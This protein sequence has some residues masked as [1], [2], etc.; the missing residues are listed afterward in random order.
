[1]PGGDAVSGSTRRFGWVPVVGIAGTVLLAGGAFSL[2]FTALKHL[3][4]RS[5]D[6]VSQ[7]WE[8][9]LIVDGM[10][11]VAT[12]G[13]VARAGR[14]GAGF[15][16][17]LLVFGAL[18]SIAGNARLAAQLPTQESSLIAMGVATI[19]PIMLLASTHMA[20]I[21]TRPDTETVDPTQTI[22]A[23][24][25]VPAVATLPPSPSGLP[26]VD[27]D[28]ALAMRAFDASSAR[29]ESDLGSSTPTRKDS[30][31]RLPVLEAPPPLPPSPSVLPGPMLATVE[32]DDDVAGDVPRTLRAEK[33]QAMR[34][35]GVPVSDIADVLGV[36]SGSVRRYLKSSHPTDQST[37]EH[38]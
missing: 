1:M 33:A 22:P 26:T 36:S 29:I 32:A 2:S 3:A 9:P 19:P 27:V 21:L 25:S 31:G 14:P 38:R 12:V 17:G 35:A 37:G 15:M 23:G 28:A 4:I 10:I 7:A 6:E 13:V 5:G 16:W 11:V 20:V 8:W 34:Q 24:S 18:V 30:P